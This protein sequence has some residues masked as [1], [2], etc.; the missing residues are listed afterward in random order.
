MHREHCPGDTGTE[1]GWGAGEIVLRK[2]VAFAGIP[3]ASTGTIF[4]SG[5]STMVA[6]GKGGSK[7]SV[8][9]LTTECVLVGSL[10]PEGAGCRQHPL[11]NGAM[12]GNSPL[13]EDRSPLLKKNDRL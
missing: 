10:F 13:P 12:S 9:E 6:R 11:N 8:G 2:Q 3:L 7:E 5:D 4:L 1:N